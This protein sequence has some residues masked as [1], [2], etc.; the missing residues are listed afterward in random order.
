MKTVKQF[1]PSISYKNIFWGQSREISRYL[2]FPE[3]S[4]KLYLALSL[5]FFLDLWFLA[6]KKERLSTTKLFLEGMQ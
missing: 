6:T 2:G 4:F 3:G 1:L 5:P